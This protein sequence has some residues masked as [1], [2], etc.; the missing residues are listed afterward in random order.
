VIDPHASLSD[1]SMLV[2][3]GPKRADGVGLQPF[4]IHDTLTCSP[5]A[6]PMTVTNGCTTSGEV[7]VVGVV[8]RLSPP[9]DPRRY[10]S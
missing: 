1:S 8:G 9:R 4:S 10:D 2:S 5:L 3:I 7:A 6:W